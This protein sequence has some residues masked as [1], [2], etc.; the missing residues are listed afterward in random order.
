MARLALL[1][2]P[3][4]ALLLLA[5]HFFRAG[6]VPFA[7][8]SVAL[9]VL[10]FVRTPWAARLL[11]VALAAGTLEWLRTAWVF[12]AAR[13]AADQPYARLLV[14]IGAVAVVTALAAWTIGNR[15]GRRHFRIDHL[16]GP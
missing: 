6:L 7:G 10:L 5:A 15:T 16:G 3:G 11:Q 8:L 4:L 2:A 9:V 1:L 14:I 13:A 12:A